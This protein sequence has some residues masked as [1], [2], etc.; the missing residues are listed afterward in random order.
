MKAKAKDMPAIITCV[1][2]GLYVYMHVI[3]HCYVAALSSL[4]KL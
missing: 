2:T 4:Y 1:T 3:A